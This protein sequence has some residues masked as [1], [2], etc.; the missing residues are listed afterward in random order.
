MT[1]KPDFADFDHTKFAPEPG[2]LLV[3]EV[4]WVIM[5]LKE[6]LIARGT[7][8]RRYICHVDDRDD[9]RVLTYVDFGIAE[10]GYTYGKFELKESV[11]EYIEDHYQITPKEFL[12]DRDLYLKPVEVELI[13]R[14]W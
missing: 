10:R 6:N 12:R 1:D 4:L 3:S 7:T 11:G 5:D 9:N 14:K 8:K 2:E 13:I